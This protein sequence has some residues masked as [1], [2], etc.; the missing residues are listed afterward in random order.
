MPGILGNQRALQCSGWISTRKP[1]QF[2]QHGKDKGVSLRFSV[3]TRLEREGLD[4]LYKLHGAA[5]MCQAGD[6]GFDEM[7]S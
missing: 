3:N 4:L 6:A 5:V 7:Q 2:L 1:G